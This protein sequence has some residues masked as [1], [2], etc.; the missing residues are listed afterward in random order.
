[1][2]PYLIE[3]LAAQYR[4]DL[5]RAARQHHLTSDRTA[6][7][8]RKRTL[9]GA[10]GLARSNRRDR[11]LLRRA[12]TGSQPGAVADHPG[13]F[14]PTCFRERALVAGLPVHSPLVDRP[15]GRGGPRHCSGPRP[16]C[17]DDLATGKPRAV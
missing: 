3:Q 14:D 15:E 13:P 11:P 10:L 6:P 12:P 17:D 1:M 4:Q 9:V 5:L 7:V 8:V 2:H 16:L